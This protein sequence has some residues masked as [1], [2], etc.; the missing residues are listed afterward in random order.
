L[1]SKRP[2]V[3]RESLGR[4]GSAQLRALVAQPVAV[5]SATVEGMRVALARVSVGPHN[6]NSWSVI[7]DTPVRAVIWS[8]IGPAPVATSLAALLLLAFGGLTLRDS[9]KTEQQSKARNRT[10]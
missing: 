10:L 4:A 7:V 6:A 2:L 3:G 1:D 8:S 9:H 5:S